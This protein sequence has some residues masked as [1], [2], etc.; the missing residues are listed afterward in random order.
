MKDSELESILNQTTQAINP[1]IMEVLTQGVDKKNQALVK[2]QVSTGGKRLRP[3]L[4]VVCCRMLGGKMKDILYPAA[5]LEILHNYT[6][7]LDDIIDHSVTRRGK[8]TTWAK[9]GQSITEEIGGHYAASIFQAALRSPKP[10]Q[11]AQLFVQTLK[12]VNDGQILDILFEQAGREREPYIRKNRYLRIT[13]KDYL[14]MVG[15]KTAFL[16]QACCEAGGIVSGAKKREIEALRN[17]GFNL[18]IVF[19][20]KDDLLD[21]FG[22]KETLGKKI[23]K[24]I[25]E[26]KLGNRVILHALEELC[27]ADR[28][29][30]LALIRRQKIGDKEIR[31]GVDLIKKTRSRE[32]T[33]RFGKKFVG[34]AKRHLKLLP[35]NKWNKIL[36]RLADFALEREN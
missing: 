5:G 16:F 21:I 15:R 31:A 23:G 20:V 32:K 30:F 29:K 8:P 11:I 1:I 35:Q 13:N 22:K 9:F 33:Y 34:K 25:Q 2:Y 17:Y 3:A 4:A 26:R 12:R 18:G 10:V 7:I 6:L 27:P 14:R 19:Q 36:A 28:K 24:D